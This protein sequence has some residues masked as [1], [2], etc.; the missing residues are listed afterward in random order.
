MGT[1]LSFYKHLYAGYTYIPL[2]GTRLCYESLVRQSGAPACYIIQLTPL[3]IGL[4]LHPLSEYRSLSFITSFLE[5]Q[6]G[7]CQ[8]CSDCSIIVAPSLVKGTR[9]VQDIS[10]K[11]DGYV[12]MCTFPSQER[13]NISVR[14][15]PNNKLL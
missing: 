9:A 12:S 4:R 13:N 1:V 10:P 7:D 2:A 3:C 15:Q 14:Y 5:Q 11:S 6:C 8:L